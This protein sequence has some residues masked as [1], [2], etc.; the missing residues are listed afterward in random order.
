MK[1]SF[2]VIVAAGLLAV[3]AT[4]NAQFGINGSSG[5][6]DPSFRG[7]ANTTWFGWGY[8]SFEG[9]V[10]NEL[11]DNPATTIGTAP[12]GVSFTQNPGNDILSSSENIYTGAA[13]A[14]DLLFALPTSGTA[15]S[16]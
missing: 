1:H 2:A 3:A 5:L 9:A 4:A 15:G 10:N 16:G 14:T 12:L 13:G 8:G 6:F 7:A 11:I